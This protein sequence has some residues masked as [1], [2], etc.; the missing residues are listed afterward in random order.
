M[1]RN[2]ACLA[3][4]LRLR[5]GEWHYADGTIAH[6]ECY[7]RKFLRYAYS[8]NVDA[9]N[10]DLVNGYYRMVKTGYR[11]R[12]TVSMILRPVRLLCDECGIRPSELMMYE[13]PSRKPEEV[14][15]RFT[16]LQAGY[17]ESASRKG[18]ATNTLIRKEGVSRRFLIFLDGRL[19]QIE[20]LSLSDCDEFLAS[21][22]PGLCE[23]SF[24]NE[25]G[26]ARE[27]VMYLC[28]E[29]QMREE[30]LRLNA[31]VGKRPA[32]TLQRFLNEDEALRLLGVARIQRQN[33]R[34]TVAV[35]AM[36]LQYM[37][38]SIDLCHLMLDDIDWMQ[39]T[40]TISASKG[41]KQRVFPLTESVRYILLDYIKNERPKTPYR[42]LILT[43]HYPHRPVGRPGSLGRTVRQVAKEAG[44]DLEGWKFG[45]HSLR[46][47]GATHLMEK[48]AEYRTISDVLMQSDNGTAACG[49][50]MT[51]LRVDIERLRDA[52]LEVLPYE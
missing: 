31:D 40:I 29:Y 1:E 38:R 24:A 23:G 26:T 16:H 28:D 25:R 12:E 49:T 52:A 7:L 44:I 2:L 36:L 14:P 37:M 50:T 41:H 4:D 27:F 6:L 32:R 5:W 35:V 19:G 8:K 13:C 3:E 51:Y 11:N 43:G 21:R 33:P 30:L 39:N 34:R 46:R 47:T 18:L 48:G 10:E 9:L 45:T 15:D 20:E 22:R 17:L 42:N